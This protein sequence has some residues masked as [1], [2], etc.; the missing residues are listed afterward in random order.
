MIHALLRKLYQTEF[1]QSAVAEQTDLSV[2]RQ[3][4]TPRVMW[5]LGIIGFSYLIGWP[6]ISALGILSIYW[7]KPMVAA[8]GGPLVYGLSHLVFMIGIYFAGAVHARIFLK[9]AA[10]TAAEKWMGEAP[11]AAPSSGTP[12]IPANT[13]PD[14]GG[15]DTGR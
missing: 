6:A 3:R 4:P 15:S 11:A 13:P 2:F 9:W 12:E 7:N 5:G 8:I 14:P 1:V 10:R